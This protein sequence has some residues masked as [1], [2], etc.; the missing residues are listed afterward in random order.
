[1]TRE[2]RNLIAAAVVAVVTVTAAVAVLVRDQPPAET[3]PAFTGPGYTDY[4]PGPTED[5]QPA[6]PPA[7]ESW[8]LDAEQAYGRKFAQ[9]RNPL[10]GTE[11][12]SDDTGGIA[13]GSTVVAA[14]GLPKPGGYSLDH[15]RLVGVDAGSGAV[16]WQ[17][18]ADGLGGCAPR[19]L[20]ESVVCFTTGYDGRDE[21]VA[22][23]ARSGEV[24]RTATDWMS[25]GIAVGGDRVFTVEGNPEDADVRVH[26]GSVADPAAHWS[27][28]VEVSGGWEDVPGTAVLTVAGDVALV[29]VAG[30][31]VG[32]DARTGRQTW[33][34]VVPDC[35][36]SA[37][38]VAGPVTLVG[39][40]DCSGHL[41]EIEARAADGR[42][43]TSVATGVAAQPERQVDPELPMVIGDGAYDRTTGK[44]VWRSDDIRD[45]TSVAVVG[46]TVLVHAADTASGIDLATGERLW[47]RETDVAA[48]YV[49]YDGDVA[50]GGNGR[51][52]F[53]MAP[54]TGEVV[55]ALEDLGEPGGQ[56]RLVVAG[57]SVVAV[58]G[59]AMAGV[60]AA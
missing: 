51:G 17:V 44:R 57:D 55:W 45:A 23:D 40:T 4:L 11:F 50:Y 15:A 8:R 26:A 42:V 33:A 36:E 16:R 24:T 14:I 27:T 60:G 37:A 25:F 5:V 21:I 22:V 35:V 52:A 54:R 28:P 41:R 59:S 49:G 39:R 29:Q 34:R 19:P 1:M 9:F 31:A 56:P 6:G 58:S 7:V 13:V 18:P 32:L 48:E 3:F 43:L 53:A 20:G 30:E 38:I 12:D 47:Q 10:W 2:T 46:E